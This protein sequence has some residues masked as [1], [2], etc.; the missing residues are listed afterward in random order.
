MK[1]KITQT[2][3]TITIWVVVSFL[4]SILYYWFMDIGL[5]WDNPEYYLN[6]KQDWQRVNMPWNTRKVIMAISSL[7]YSILAITKIFDIWD[8]KHFN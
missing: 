3:L 4:M 7:A 8:E 1:N 6:E 5:I 2:A